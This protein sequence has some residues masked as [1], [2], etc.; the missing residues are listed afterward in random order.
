MPFCLSAFHAKAGLEYRLARPAFS[1]QQFCNFV[2]KWLIVLRFFCSGLNEF[3]T[4]NKNKKIFTASE[5]NP[6]FD[7]GNLCAIPFLSLIT[8]QDF[9]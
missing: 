2:Q 9:S 5:K 4:F 3:E 1:F 7:H 8:P 6:A